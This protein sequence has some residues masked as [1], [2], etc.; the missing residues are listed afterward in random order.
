M[1]VF[2]YDKTFEGLLTCIFDAYSRKVFPQKLV[3]EGEPSPLFT[4]EEHG[5]ITETTKSSRVWKALEKKLPK[6][7]CSML[8]HVWLS[9]LPESDDLLFRYIRKVIDSPHNVST[10]FTDDDVLE[11]HKIAKKVSKERLN[12]IQ[13]VRF[14]K[15]ADDMFFAPVS[16]IF[17][18]LPLTMNYF[19]DRFADQKWLIYDIRRRYGFYYDL[20]TAQEVSLDDDT[21]LLSGK[22]DEEL[23]AK[24]EKLFQKMWKSYFQALTIKERFNPRLQRQ[25]MPRRYWKFLPEKN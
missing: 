12:L 3:G 17:N 21:H 16:P 18:S 1:I 15:A 14:Q 2:R 4:E 24:D 20:K 8:M 19:T 11:V 9:E 23:M 6:E 22:L 10:N 5:V 13:F 25:H 7:A